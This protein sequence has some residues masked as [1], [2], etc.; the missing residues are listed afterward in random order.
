MGF[1]LGVWARVR[2]GVS[3]WGWD[4][5][6]GEAG[7]WAGAQPASQPVRRADWL[8]GENVGEQVRPAQKVG[9]QVRFSLFEQVLLLRPRFLELRQRPVPKLAVLACELQRGTA[10]GWRQSMASG[11][12]AFGH[13]HRAR[14][15]LA[16]TA[17]R[18]A[19]SVR[20][21]SPVAAPGV[22]WRQGS[23]L[24]GHAPCEE[25]QNPCES[26]RARRPA[27]PN[28]TPAW[29]RCP[30][31]GAPRAVRWQQYK[32]GT[33]PGL[34]TRSML[35]YILFF[36]EEGMADVLAPRLRRVG[37]YERLHFVTKSVRS[38]NISHGCWVLP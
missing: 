1:G 11:T 15:A 25:P 37:H 21:R 17:W 2:V 27:P 31:A 22:H 6:A 7:R 36:T 4:I 16:P 12:T 33:L 3:R 35:L 20:V 9:R 28:A 38:R 30:P 18:G 34:R 23:E 8:S 26:R 5:G 10:T 13:H 29:I 19:G 24:Y 14:S 32:A